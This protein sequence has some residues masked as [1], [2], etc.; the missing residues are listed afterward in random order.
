MH[1]IVTLQF[2]QQANYLGTHFW[3]TQE[4]YFTYSADEEESPIDH[5]IHFRSG[6]A[7]DGSDTFT[8]RT[9]IYDLKGAFGTLRREN[10]LYGLD[11][12]ADAREQSLW[13][14]QPT[15]L[16]QPPLPPNQYQQHLDAGLEPPPLTTA[17]V[18]F[19]SDYNRVFY[20]PRSIVQLSEYELNSSLMPF[21]RWET[22]EELLR[23]LDREHD[24]LDRDLRPW[25]EECDQLAAVQVFAG[26]DDAWGGFC[27]RYVERVRDELGKGAIW[28]WGCEDGARRT[29]EKQRI[30]LVNTAYSL[31]QISSAASMYIPLTNIPSASPS[32]LSVDTAS[33]WHTSALQATALETATLPTRLR[34][35]RSSPDDLEALLCN[36]GTR[37]I[38]SLSLSIADP[39]ALHEQTEPDQR[40]QPRDRRTNG[41][42][43]GFDHT[44]GADTPDRETL[45]IDLHPRDSNLAGDA[46][47]LG[48]RPHIFDCAETLRGRWKRDGEVARA[49]LDA[50]DRFAEGTRVR[51][52]HTSL[53][54][55]LPTSFPPIFAFRPDRLAVRTR[56]AT[57]AA[58]AAR[59]RSVVR[60]VRG[61][62]SVD[63]REE[64]CDGLVRVAEGYEEGWEG[65]AGSSGEE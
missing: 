20:H 57:S 29:R 52:T 12:T 37:R 11:S 45:D 14:G 65:E 40:A 27:A 30:Q 25:L 56:L 42:T 58:V 63:V 24:L 44:N 55:P 36:D 8:P 2:G 15:L 10:A 49:N 9:L 50:R 22:G 17:S 3:N 26:A 59:V 64:L 4:S 60:D 46:R 28:V 16:A 38:A 19:W 6:I 53:L 7:A 33:A 51:I 23:N 5:D 39:L 48:S 43:N 41:Y 1:E 54:L 34:T 35:D 47:R 18:R 32:Y 31:H 62:V 61:W 21:E 13:N